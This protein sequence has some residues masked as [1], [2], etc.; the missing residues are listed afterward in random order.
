M[1][2]DYTMNEYRITPLH[3]AAAKGKLDMCQLLVSMGA[4]IDALDDKTF[5]PLHLA[6]K[7]G[8]VSVVKLLVSK[9]AYI[10]AI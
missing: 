7:E 8:Q 10:D 4:H 3:F 2:E 1:R 9:G 5:T 6:A